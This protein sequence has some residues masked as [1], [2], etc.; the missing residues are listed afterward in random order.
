MSSSQHPTYQRLITIALYRVLS[1][2]RFGPIHKLCAC[3]SVS[4]RCSKRSICFVLHVSAHC[5]T[6]LP[7]ISLTANH[8]WI[9]FAF[10]THFLLP[11]AVV[12]TVAGTIIT[13]YLWMT[14]THV[15]H[16]HSR[17]SLC[18]SH[19]H[20]AKM[21]N[22]RSRLRDRRHHKS[23][24]WNNIVR[25]TSRWRT[26]ISQAPNTYRKSRDREMSINR[27]TG[28]TYMS[29]KKK[30]R[31]LKTMTMTYVLRE[32]TCPQLY[33]IQMK[34]GDECTQLIANWS[35][36]TVSMERI[37]SILIH[38]RHPSGS[39]YMARAEQYQN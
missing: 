22:V 9:R 27:A 17:C 11:A 13:T 5:C 38:R 34:I 30:E 8:E 37:S 36:C 12:A 19:S 39:Q 35:T 20:N 33:Q 32:P 3:V 15:V 14:F 24:Q 26:G 7:H 31:K 1:V 4:Y 2:R 23:L 21:S 25:G 28:T 18:S 10:V 16:T 29:K 6:L